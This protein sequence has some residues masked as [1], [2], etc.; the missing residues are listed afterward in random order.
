MIT[1]APT[2]TGYERVAIGRNGAEI[3]LSS[4]IQ[5]SVLLLRTSEMGSG[6]I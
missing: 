4:V 1:M 2:G 6:C 5:E 3:I